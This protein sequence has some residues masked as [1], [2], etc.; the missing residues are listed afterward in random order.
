MKIAQQSM[1]VVL[2]CVLGGL[3]TSLVIGVKS[4]Q[5]QKIQEVHTDNQLHLRDIEHQ[6]L[7]LS[8]WFVT[9]DLFFSQQDSYLESGINIQSKQLQNMF[10]MKENKTYQAGQFSSEQ[11]FNQLTQEIFQTRQSLHQKI[12]SITTIINRSSRLLGSQGKIWN[13]NLLKADAI[14]GEVILLLNELHSQYEQI[15]NYSEDKL[16]QDKSNLPI[17]I[18]AVIAL[19]FLLVFW[20]WRLASIS[21]I[22]PLEYLNSK[23]NRNLNLNPDDQQPFQNFTLLKGPQ[24]VVELSHSLQNYAES[25]QQQI[26]HSNQAR[27][28]SVSDKNYLSTIMDSITDAII[29]L[30]D[31]GIIRNCNSATYQLFDTNEKKTQGKSINTLLE[32]T[33]SNFASISKLVGTR[34]E[35]NITTIKG[36]NK[37]I[38]LLITSATQQNKTFFVL[39]IHDT[40]KRVE[41][42]KNVKRLNQ[43]L[44]SASRKVGVAEVA[45]SILH[46]VG[47]ILNSVHIST[48]LISDTLQNSRI[49]GINKLADIMSNK[50]EFFN[51][52][53]K[54]EMIPEYLNSLAARID[55][56]REI[57]MKEVTLLNNNINHIEEII[58]SQQQFASTS[59]SYEWATLSDLVEDA[60]NINRDIIDQYNFN[61]IKEFEDIKDVNIEKFKIMQILVNLITNAKDAI[62][63]SKNKNP[64]IILRIRSINESSIELTVQDNGIG[65]SEDINKKIFSYGF[66]TKKTGHGFGLHSCALTAKEMGGKLIMHSAG[67][68]LGAKFVLI[69]PKDNAP[70]SATVHQIRK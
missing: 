35:K 38:E 30:D 48:N 4:Y 40:S 67:H 13:N 17:I 33:Y 53:D 64:T 43:R 10:K 49:K 8:Q 12:G 11:E 32:D 26:E 21:S 57:T 56:E 1:F 29:T 37:S 66:T 24:E 42:E 62:L 15:G 34:L 14:S 59:S 52:K 47:N 19:Y 27:I 46:N 61:L 68:K 54:V 9:I 23:A 63:Q 70:K 69:I 6:K 20:A 50:K 22:K 16:K 2:A 58:S 25:L 31:Q 3:C 5:L 41:N 55:Q 65:I 44:V 45:T 39:A 18:G 60:I 7:M 51:D 28:K 36:N